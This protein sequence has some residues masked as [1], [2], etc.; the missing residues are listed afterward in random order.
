MKQVKKVADHIECK[1]LHNTAP[2][3]IAIPVQQLLDDYQENCIL[4]QNY[5]QEILT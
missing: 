2:H 5:L 1:F 3:P 4:Q